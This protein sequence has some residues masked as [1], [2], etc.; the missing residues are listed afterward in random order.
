MR[1][2][3][4]GHDICHVDMLKASITKI[5]NTILVTNTHHEFSDCFF[6]VMNMRLLEHYTCFFD[7]DRFDCVPSSIHPSLWSRVVA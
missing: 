6:A 1:S 2:I 3:R 4:V 7:I 5:P